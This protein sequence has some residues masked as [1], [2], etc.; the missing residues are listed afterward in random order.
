MN[1]KEKLTITSSA[2]AFASA[3]VWETPTKLR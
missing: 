2:S 1:F 3:S